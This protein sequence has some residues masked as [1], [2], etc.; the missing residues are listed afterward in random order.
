MVLFDEVLRWDTYLLFDDA[1][2]VDMRTD[3]GYIHAVIPPNEGNQ[4]PLL[5]QI[6][7]AAET[8]STLAIVVGG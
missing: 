8:V 7:G 4:P 3:T 1:R 5:L 6:V 2:D